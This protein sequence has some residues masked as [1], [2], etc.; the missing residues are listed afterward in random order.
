MTDDR[1]AFR[2]ALEK[3][4]DSELLKHMPGFVAEKLLAL[5][6]DERCN[7]TRQERTGE[8]ANH[9]NG[10]R[11][12]HPRRHHRAEGAQAAQGKRVSEFVE[13]RRAAEKTMTAVISRSPDLSRP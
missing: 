10:V 1:M 13:P 12:A 8:R 9:R 2:A 7:A 6:I 11:L 4:S 3:A 5:D